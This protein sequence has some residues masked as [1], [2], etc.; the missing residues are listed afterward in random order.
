[1]RKR[2]HIGIGAFLLLI[3]I[4]I[5]PVAAV[6]VSVKQVSKMVTGWR[7]LSKAP[8]GMHLSLLAE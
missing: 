1:M 7:V 3:V 2:T 8:L 4:S 5:I 6:P